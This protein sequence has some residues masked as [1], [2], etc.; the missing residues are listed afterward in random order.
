MATMYKAKLVD[1]T[2][3]QL[4]TQPLDTWEDNGDWPEGDMNL[5]PLHSTIPFEGM[6][7]VDGWII[8]GYQDCNTGD[9]YYDWCGFTELEKAYTTNEKVAQLILYDSNQWEK[10]EEEFDEE[11]VVSE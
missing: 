7:V 1:F 4:D 10:W 8:V 2:S 9:E 11:V 5:L 3:G 6:K